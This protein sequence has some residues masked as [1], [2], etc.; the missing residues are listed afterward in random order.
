VIV[1]RLDLG[2]VQGVGRDS[3]RVSFFDDIRT[4]FLQ[5]RVQGL[6]ALTLLHPQP[7]KIHEDLWGIRKRRQ[8]DRRHNAVPELVL[9]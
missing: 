7:P 9:P 8:D 1:V 3:K 4:A 2:S 6:N 5:F